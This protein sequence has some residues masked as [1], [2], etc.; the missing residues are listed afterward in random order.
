MSSTPV[1]EGFQPLYGFDKSINPYWQMVPLDGEKNVYLSG[2]AGMSVQV[3]DTRIAQ[4]SEAAADN[5]VESQ[6]KRLLKIAGKLYGR[7]YLEVRDGNVLKTRLEV[8]VKKQKDVSLAFN[9]V[10]DKANHTTIKNPSDVPEWMK[11]LN[12]IFHPQTNILFTH[13]ST[14]SVRIN[15]NLGPEVDSIDENLSGWE[16]DAIVKERDASADVN[17]FFVWK[18]VAH[19]SEGAAFPKGSAFGKDCLISDHIKRPLEIEVLVM[20]HEIGH[21]LGIRDDQHFYHPNNKGK[22]VMYYKS[23]FAGAEIPKIHTNMVNP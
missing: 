16:W 11:K 22:F 23:S 18:L 8:E 12:E 17:L 15:N 4:V 9:F 5:N 19:S 13:R 20:A 21:I 3:S 7:T 10:A 6:Q 14:R 2:A 1:F